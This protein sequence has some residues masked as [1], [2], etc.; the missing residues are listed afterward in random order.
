VRP[1]DHHTRRVKP[2]RRHPVGFDI[3]AVP[4]ST[5]AEGVDAYSNHA[6]TGGEI[7]SPAPCTQHRHAVWCRPQPGTGF[8]C[9]NTINGSTYAV[10]GAN[11]L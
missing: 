7:V 2:E 1:S 5:S 11:C 4:G 6:L 10:L 9:V 8:T 3:D